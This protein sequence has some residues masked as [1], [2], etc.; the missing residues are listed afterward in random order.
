MPH[1]LLHADQGA[2]L[3]TSQSI[4]SSSSCTL[5]GHM[6]RLHFLYCSVRGQV[7]VVSVGCRV[8]DR[9]RNAL[10]PPHPTEQDDH[11]VHEDMSQARGS[12][13]GLSSHS[14]VSNRPGHSS[15]PL[16]GDI[17]IWRTRRVL[18]MPHSL[19]Q[20]SHDVH[21]PTTH[22]TRGKGSD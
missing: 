1:T 4:T 8:M 15:P 17:M 10:P 11:S 16:R 9:N 19:E 13:H 18:P 6:S 3:V 7:A 2:Q 20:G 12:G 21:S 22:P 14:F 5:T